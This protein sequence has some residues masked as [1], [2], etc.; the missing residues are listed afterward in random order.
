MATKVNRRQ[1]ILASIVMTVL[2]ISGSALM[3][4]PNNSLQGPNRI[5]TDGNNMIQ[6]ATATGGSNQNGGGDNG[7]R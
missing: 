5:L 3:G 2:L 1:F 4:L 6:T 7:W